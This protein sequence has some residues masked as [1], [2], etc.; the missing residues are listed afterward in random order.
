MKSNLICNKESGISLLLAILILALILGVALGLNTI[1]LQQIRMTRE[2]GNSVIAFY[3]ADT[4]IEEA[5]M[6]RDNP[7]SSCTQDSP[8]PLGNG[9]TYYLS[10]SPTSP[11]DC[12]ALDY[13]IKSVGIFKG[14][15]RGIEI[16]Y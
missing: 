8:C 7:S 13:C 2:M 9:A 4:G 14:T 15:R 16:D 12:V 10:I 6:V 5:L 1:L 11:P 3:A